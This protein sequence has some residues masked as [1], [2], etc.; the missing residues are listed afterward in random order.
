VDTETLAWPKEFKPETQGH[1]LVEA[2]RDPFGNQR[3]VLGIRLDKFD[4]KQKKVDL[5]DTPI[6]I[7]LFNTG[8]TANG[9]VIGGCSVYYVP[10]RV[11]DRWTVEC[12]GTLDP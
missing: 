3:K 4:L 5:L 10:K 2:R 8:G 12:Y 7:C 11:G 6:E 9:A 1:K